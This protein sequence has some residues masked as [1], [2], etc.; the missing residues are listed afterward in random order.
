MLAS[1]MRPILDELLTALKVHEVKISTSF[2]LR[3]CLVLNTSCKGAGR[4]NLI[5]QLPLVFPSKGRLV[6]A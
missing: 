4:R 3:V 6:G 2:V 1:H 5:V